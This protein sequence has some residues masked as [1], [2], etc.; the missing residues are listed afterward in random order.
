VV[1]VAAEAEEAEEAEE[2]V[3]VVVAAAD[4]RLH[5]RKARHIRREEDFCGTH[6]SKN[7]RSRHQ[8]SAPHRNRKGS[9]SL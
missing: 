2:E 4:F 7:P 3:V 8:A 1:V 5:S 6:A 9:L